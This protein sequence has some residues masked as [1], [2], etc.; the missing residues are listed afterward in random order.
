MRL[1]T[2]HILRWVLLLLASTPLLLPAYH[3]ARQ[4]FLRHQME[5]RLEKTA[6][7]TISLTGQLHWAKPGKELWVSGRLFDVKNMT[8]TAN[9]YHVTGLYDHEETALA[10]QAHQQS[11]NDDAAQLLGQWLQQCLA[12]PVQP[13]TAATVAQKRMV[14]PLSHFASPL[15]SQSIGV[16]TPPPDQA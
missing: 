12:P 16:T 15:H 7:H 9:G 10:R 11:Q 8:P 3:L 4:Q 14:P 6:L 5:E 2:L 13:I 1:A